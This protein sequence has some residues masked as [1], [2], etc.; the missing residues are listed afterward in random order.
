MGPCVRV[1]VAVGRQNHIWVVDRV[2][3]EVENYT[4]HLAFPSLPDVSY[5]VSYNLQHRQHHH[6]RHIISDDTLTLNFIL[7]MRYRRNTCSLCV[8]H[9][10]FTY[11]K[12]KMRREKEWENF[13][14]F[15]SGNQWIQSPFYD[16]VLACVAFDWCFDPT[17][18]H[19]NFSLP[20]LISSLT[21][22]VCAIRS[23]RVS[24]H[25]CVALPSLLRQHTRFDVMKF[26]QQPKCITEN[27]IFNNIRPQKMQMLMD[28]L[29]TF[30][31]QRWIAIWFEMKWTLYK[32]Q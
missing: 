27:Q 3:G 25:R 5:S 1:W 29:H 4:I 20:S 12:V 17:H 28:T 7:S 15:W 31:C 11:A 21:F 8:C 9:S 19:R 16:A 30:S 14:N 10:Q 2:V 18:W 32:N 6:H 13:T 26:E 23:K 22:S 24:S